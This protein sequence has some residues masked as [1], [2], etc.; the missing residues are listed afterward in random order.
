VLRDAAACA[1]GKDRTYY[2]FPTI[3]ITRSQLDVG[4]L[5]LLIPF[6]SDQ[7]EVH[8]HHR[9]KSPGRG[10]SQPGLPALSGFKQAKA[11]LLH[12]TNITGAFLKI[13]TV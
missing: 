5:R 11:I 4:P 13:S 7:N 10:A 1:I 8:G 3:V 12:D 6:G 2:T 9:N